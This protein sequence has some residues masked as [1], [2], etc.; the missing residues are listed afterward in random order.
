MRDPFLSDYLA[1]KRSDPQSQRKAVKPKPNLTQ[2][3]AQVSPDMSFRKVYCQESGVQ[4]SVLG[5]YMSI[6]PCCCCRCMLCSRHSQLPTPIFLLTRTQTLAVPNMSYWRG[7]PVDLLKCLAS[8][9][10]YVRG[11]CRNPVFSRAPDRLFVGDH[12]Q[13]IKRLATAERQL[14]CGGCHGM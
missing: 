13:E 2:Q 11:T 7:F 4:L 12:R 6:G 9:P 1:H 14:P 5:P 3:T 10:D 8:H